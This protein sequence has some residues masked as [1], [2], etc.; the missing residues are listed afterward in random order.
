MEVG[1]VG[2]V[3]RSHPTPDPA[4]LVMQRSMEGL[5]KELAKL[6]ANTIDVADPRPAAQSVPVPKTYTRAVPPRGHPGGTGASSTEVPFPC[7]LMGGPSFTPDKQ[8]ICH[9]CQQVGH[10]AKN[11]EA[12]RA[13]LANM[14]VNQ[15]LQ[16]KTE[17]QGN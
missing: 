6:K 15:A 9:E 1:V 16:T 12:R 8:P 11:C 10:I 7:Y 14:A 13:R 4:L 2:T 5:H 3:P 17:N